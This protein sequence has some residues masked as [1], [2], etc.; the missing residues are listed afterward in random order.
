VVTIERDVYVPVPTGDVEVSPNFYRNL[1]RVDTE[2]FV[3][4][5]GEDRLVALAMR[6][7]ADR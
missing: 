3:R 5:L 2:D 1:P 4:Y 6:M 7:G